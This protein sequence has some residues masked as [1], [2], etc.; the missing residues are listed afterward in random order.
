MNML[1]PPPPRDPTPTFP[2]R[3]RIDVAE[4]AGVEISMRRMMQCVGVAPEAVGR[5][6]Q[7]A[8]DTADPI[9]HQAMAEEG[10]VAAIM[11]DHE[12]PHQEAR[13][14]HGKDQRQ[15]IAD[16]ERGPDQNP[17]HDQRHK[18]DADLENAAPVAGLA[19]ARQDLR[20]TS[21]PGRRR[22][23]MRGMLVVVQRTF[24]FRL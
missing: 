9:V 14:R 13:G 11:L 10:A 18:R 12:Q 23:R 8:D 7:H 3:Q 4:A 17:Q 19:I 15:P 24:F 5:Q 21:R 22:R 6:R 2:H 20:P 1:A 16:V